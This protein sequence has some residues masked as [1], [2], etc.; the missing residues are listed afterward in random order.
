MASSLGEQEVSHRGRTNLKSR[1][2]HIIGSQAG[3]Q[4]LGKTDTILICLRCMRS[5]ILQSGLQ[6]AAQ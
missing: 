6:A 3:P 5:G 4:L 2:H 1:P